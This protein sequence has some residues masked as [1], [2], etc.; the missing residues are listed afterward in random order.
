M[1]K[2]FKQINL[3]TIV[4]MLAFVSCEQ[5]VIETDL[6]TATDQELSLK[7]AKVKTPEISF[8]IVDGIPTNGICGTLP[9]TDFI[10]GQNYKAGNVYIAH[11]DKKLY[12]S[13]V[14]N[15]AWTLDC[16]HLFIGKF[17]DIPFNN[18]GNPQIG[19]FPFYSC[20][21]KGTDK[22]T[23]EFNR[24]DFDKSVTIVVHGEVSGESCET[25]FAF[26]TEFPDASRWGWY[27]DYTMKDCIIVVPPR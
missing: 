11:T 2:T 24:S 7:S 25:A 4:L 27:I 3:I 13:I 17:D 1:K 26:G 21:K 8:S 9:V 18:S 6:T 5:S 20:F 15:G 10:A 14:M 16:T 22:V 23:Y 12:V 19:H